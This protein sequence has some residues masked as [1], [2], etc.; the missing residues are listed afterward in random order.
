MTAEGPDREQLAAR[1]FLRK[2][3]QTSHLSTATNHHPDS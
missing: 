3:P 1:R 2:R